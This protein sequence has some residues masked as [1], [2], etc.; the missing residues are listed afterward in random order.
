[1]RVGEAKRKS[2]DDFCDALRYAITLIPWDLSAI[3]ADSA[4]TN[5]EDCIAEEVTEKSL[6]I[7]ARRGTPEGFNE[8]E[9]QSCD[10]EIEEWNSYYEQ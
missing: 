8:E 10:Q 3:T 9:I 7:A 2:A 5:P 4:P 6:E 1:L